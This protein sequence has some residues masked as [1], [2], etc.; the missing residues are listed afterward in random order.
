[1]SWIPGL[2]PGFSAKAF[3]SY[4]PQKPRP[5]PVNTTTCTESSLLAWPK[6]E[7][8]SSG[9]VSLIAFNRSGR[10]SVIL[11]TLS[12]DSYNTVPKFISSLRHVLPGEEFG[13]EDELIKPRGAEVAVPWEPGYVPVLFRN[14]LQ[15]SAHHVCWS[16]LLPLQNIFLVYRFP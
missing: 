14:I 8:I 5:A 4:P 3:K 6:A 1:M 16:N 15:Q 10:L 2:A 9:M 12:F 11:A 13:T 7:A